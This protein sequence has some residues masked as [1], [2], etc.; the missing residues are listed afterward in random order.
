MNSP[1]EENYLKV[2]YALNTAGTKGASTN[3]IA[4]KLNTKASSVTDMLKKL[5]EKK[6]IH[7][8]KYQGSTLTDKGRQLA[9]NIVRK[10]RLWEVFLVDKLKFKW[11]EVHEIAEQLEHVQSR[12]LS[13]RLDD[14][15]GNPKYDPHGDPIPDADGNIKPQLAKK[16]L[17]EIKEKENAVI[18][19]VADSSPELLRHLEHQKLTLGSR[20]SVL[21]VY[22]YDRSML[23]KLESGKELNL[24]HQ[25]CKN[26]WV[27]LESQ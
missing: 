25:I 15:L 26:I 2:I 3:D 16:Y 23:L 20:L 7:Y 9:L 1:T 11:D 17:A 8:K 6:L 4:E 10:H 12:E 21:A 24:S 13:R 18:I 14:Y 22:E 19:G 27:K 5:A